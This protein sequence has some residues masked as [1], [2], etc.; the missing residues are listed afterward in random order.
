MILPKG[1]L[2]RIPHSICQA[3]SL[4]ETLRVKLPCIQVNL[5]VSD[6]TGTISRS[7]GKMVM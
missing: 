2:S 3:P 4:L 7:I 6:R 5:G 1:E